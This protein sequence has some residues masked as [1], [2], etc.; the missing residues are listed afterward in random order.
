MLLN[1]FATILGAIIL[2][3]IILPWF[4]IAVAAC[5]V[6]YLMSAAYYRASAREIKV[7]TAIMLPLGVQADIFF[8]IQRLGTSCLV[9]ADS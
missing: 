8:F 6:F 9:F 4:M 7:R 3:A 2:I 5:A 1:T